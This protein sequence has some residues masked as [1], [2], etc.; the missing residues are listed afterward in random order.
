[1][2]SSNV[3]Y[4]TNAAIADSESDDVTNVPAASIITPEG[5]I[6]YGSNVNVD[7]KTR[8]KLKVFYTAPNN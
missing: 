7:D 2:L 6:L 8:M 4:T 1:M 5:T 3:N